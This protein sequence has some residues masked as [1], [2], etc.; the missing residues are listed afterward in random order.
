MTTSF[1]LRQTYRIDEWVAQTGQDT[2][3]EGPI[4]TPGASTGFADCSEE[5]TTA[6]LGIIYFRT[7]PSVLSP[8]DVFK[9]FNSS[10]CSELFLYCFLLVH[11]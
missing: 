7:F 1:L 8:H 5:Q 2:Q 9:P 3:E 4:Y 6:K 10:L 11:F